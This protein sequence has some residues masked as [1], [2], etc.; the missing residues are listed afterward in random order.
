MS[1]CLISCRKSQLTLNLRRNTEDD[2]CPLLE[3][4]AAKEAGID[5][6]AFYDQISHSTLAGWD[7]SRSRTLSLDAIDDQISFGLTPFYA[8]YEHES[9]S[10]LLKRKAILPSGPQ[11]CPTEV[12]TNTVGPLGED[13]GIDLIHSLPPNDRPQLILD[14]SPRHQVRRPMPNFVS[15]QGLRLLLQCAN[16]E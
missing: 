11:A 16:G 13:Q 1:L 7:A 8:P 12:P 3:Q 10:N 15:G 14:T 5:S 6:D 4:A 2:A 9:P